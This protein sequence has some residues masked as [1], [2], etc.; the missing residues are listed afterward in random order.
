[1]QATVK[2]EKII[3]NILRLGSGLSVVLMAA[4]IGLFLA[5][6]N[7]GLGIPHVGFM[8]FRRALTGSL[9]L[10]PEPLMSLGIIV[11]L[12]TPFFRVVGALVTFLL[13][14]KDYK[15]ALISLGVLVILTVSFF[16][17]GIK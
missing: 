8:G 17:P 1:M 12:L 7:F 6:G 3:V 14:E 11:L 15:Y 5:R 4:G 16:V 13:V 10:E 9:V 2:A